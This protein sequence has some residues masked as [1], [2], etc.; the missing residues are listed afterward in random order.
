LQLLCF[1]CRQ[2]AARHGIHDA[3]ARVGYS[4][5]RQA[6]LI[7][8][9]LLALSMC[10]LEATPH[11]LLVHANA[12]LTIL[13][14]TEGP[15]GLLWLAA[16][17]GLYRFDGFHYHKITS[18]PFSSARFIAFTR[19]GSL[20]CGGLDGLTRLRQNRFEVLMSG[21]VSGMA[22]YPDQV[23]V[24]RIRDLVRVGLDGSTRRRP[25]TRRDLAVDAGGRMWSVCVKPERGCWIEPSRPDEIHFIELP[26]GYEQVI[27]D[28]EGRIWAANQE[29][30]ALLEHGRPALMLERQRS[31]AARRPGPLLAGRKGEIW[32]LGETIRGL[33]SKIVF[34]DRAEHDRYS[35]VCGFEDSRGH[36]WVSSLG[37][38]LV[39]W[40]PD[41]EWQRWFPEN[42]GNEFA[43]Q[44][45]R[46]Q[47]ASVLLA[48]YNHI[49]RLD[50]RAD[51][52]S[53]LASEPH[54]YAA[55]LP[56]DGGGFLAS[57]RKL[58]VGR[59]SPE[60]R[61]VERL[62]NPLPTADEYR[63]IVR[64]G[65][66]RVWVG[67]KL[68]LLRIE[69]RPGSLRLRTEDLPGIRNGEDAQA[70]DL[71]MDAAGRLWVGYAGGVA[72]L[73][74]EDRW[75]KLAT[76]EPVTLLRSFALGGDDVWVAHRRAGAFSRLQRKG[77]RWSVTPFAAHAGYTPVDTHFLKRDS[78]GW[79]WRGSP[80]GVHI[81]DGRHVAPNDWIHL[82]LENGLATNET[83]QYG[84][85]EDSDGTVWIAGE[86]GVSHLRPDTSWFD[87]P[88][89][90]P[91]PQVTRVEVDGREVLFPEPLPAALPRATKILR[92]DVGTLHASP[93]RDQPLRYRLLPLSK[94]WQ[95]SRDGTFEFRNL[96]ENAY[97]L[98]VGYTG[99]GP[100][101]VAAYPFRIGA[102]GASGSWRWPIGLLIAAGALVPLVRR[103]PW[104]ERFVFRMQHA[105]F[106]LRR[107]YGH[108]RLR[109]RSVGLASGDDYSGRTL[110]GRYHL[111]RIVS[112]GGFSVVYEARD[113][114]D[115]NAR[116]A[117]K[118]LNRSSAEDGWVRDRFAHEVAALRS[119]EHPGVVR[120]LDS[121][122]SAR[123]EPCLA[124]PFL[125]GMTLRAALSQ[126]PFEPAR[127]GRIVR[128]LGDA[129]SEVHGRGI[130][131]RDLKPENLMLLWPGTDGEQPVIIDFG[132]AGLRTG[133]NEL[134]ATT[135][136]SGSFHYMAPERL[137]GH[138]SAATDVFSFGVMIL[139]MLTGKRLADLNAMFSDRSFRDELEEALSARLGHDAAKTLAQ[140]LSPAYNPEPRRRP[141]PVNEWAEEMAAVMNQT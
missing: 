105:L 88:R 22:A 102:G 127:V 62:E 106:L 130:I 115:G 13:S 135:L 119:V 23:F 117:V 140:L 93:F 47:K 10:V 49:Y 118:V 16:A 1:Q 92:I 101:A 95:F 51:R 98:E 39:E 14:I 138:Y 65:K 79:I 109:G 29:H 96:R 50:V 129:L 131:H 12:T 28:A 108:R 139:E 60:G 61:L 21:E 134:A 113:L 137:T 69:G 97:S 9:V 19:D 35:P 126:V 30:A 82:H 33:T 124:M 67:N 17:D 11:R 73:D 114:R 55:L 133:E 8:S 41:P 107:R 7:I 84:F 75:Q 20:W 42:F 90:A 53:P 128:R 58:G 112:R 110:A 68:A 66:R 100:S 76:D 136:M 57:I 91:A 104:F 31:H 52:W 123:G 40:I 94:D 27:P 36:L 3:G 121:W 72:W 48:A 77:E 6:G 34:H 71:E 81:S 87:A 15:D 24:K 103:T 111:S 37:Q 80:E 59:L 25:E 4:C 99:N 89:T 46:D 141:A 64:D 122:V 26:S 116:L 85:F 2:W 132:T 5:R 54:R 18:Y 86:E 32:F 45:V 120:V 83:D 74:S 43:V 78:R 70:V 125:D 44:V 38:G 56:L 63:K